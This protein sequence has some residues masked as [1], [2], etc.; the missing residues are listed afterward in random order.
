VPTEGHGFH[1]ATIGAHSGL[2]PLA[3]N[4]FNQK[5]SCLK[6]YEYSTLGLAAI[7]TKVT[8]Y[9]DEI[10]HDATGLLS[11]ASALQSHPGL[12]L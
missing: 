1:L 11:D 3:A 5:K 9:S 10:T 4:E 8:P 6:W 7:A 12:G 2:A